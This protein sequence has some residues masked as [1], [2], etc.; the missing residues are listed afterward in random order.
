MAAAV[1]DARFKR[2]MRRLA[3]AIL[4]AVGV[5]PFAAGLVALAHLAPARGPVAIALTVACFLVE[6]ALLQ[7]CRERLPLVGNAA[8]RRRLQARVLEDTSSL[9]LPEASQWHFVGFSP[10]HELRTWEGETDRDVG[11]LT[12]APGVMVFRGDHYAWKLRAEAIQRIDMVAPPG[13]PQ[14]IVVFWH[15]PG[16]PTRAFTI[17]SREG[18]TLRQTVAATARLYQAMRGW[19]ERNDHAQD[20]PSLGLPPTDLSG[21]FPL[22]QP[23]SGSC[24]AL[25][26]VGIIVLLSLW[27][28]V[29]QLVAA[30]L[31]CHAVLWAGMLTSAGIVVSS[32][33]LGYLQR[34]E[35]NLPPHLRRNNHAAR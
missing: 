30:R 12:L 28:V 7:V 9:P 34:Y 1:F 8:L 22:D 4:F 31:Y 15:V 2:R 3:G 18:R 20:V 17:A 21:S 13:A 19:V 25:F 24:A 29:Q 26:S 6:I 11:F 23:P 33:I 35:A 5:G 32:Y 27:Y 16:E 14:R 10:G